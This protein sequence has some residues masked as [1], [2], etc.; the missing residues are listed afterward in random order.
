MQGYL[1]TMRLLTFLLVLLALYVRQHQ[2]LDVQQA[3]KSVQAYRVTMNCCRYK[4]PA[5]DA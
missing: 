2:R 5:P 1:G 4:L 3:S